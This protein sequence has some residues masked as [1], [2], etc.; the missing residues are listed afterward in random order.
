MLGTNQFRTLARCFYGDGSIPLFSDY[1][2]SYL[3]KYFYLYCVERSLIGRALDCE[4]SLCEFKSRRSHFFM[5]ELCCG[6]FFIWTLKVSLTY[7]VYVCALHAAE[8]YRI[9]Y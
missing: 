1:F 6:I 9:K 3:Y 7:L 4:S 8:M 2:R 5:P